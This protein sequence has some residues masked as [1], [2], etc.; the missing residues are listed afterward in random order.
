MGLRSRC[1]GALPPSRIHV[2]CAACLREYKDQKFARARREAGSDHSDPSEDE[3]RGDLYIS[4]NNRI[5]GEYKARRNMQT[6]DVDTAHM[7][8]RDAGVRLSDTEESEE[9]EEEEDAEEL[10][11][12]LCNVSS[13]SYFFWHRCMYY[14]IMEAQG[15]WAGLPEEARIVCSTCFSDRLGPMSRRFPPIDEWAAQWTR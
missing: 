11:C 3:E 10:F 13:R 14:D 9:E 12:S 7:V 1:G 15:R 8:L 4:R 2:W 5:P 6:G